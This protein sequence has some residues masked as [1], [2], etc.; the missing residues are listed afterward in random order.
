MLTPL[1]WLAVGV[2]ILVLWVALAGF[3]PL[4]LRA[5][6]MERLERDAA[7][8]AEALKV[9]TFERQEQQRLE[10]LRAEEYARQAQITRATEQLVGEAAHD[11]S[12]QISLQDD[13]LGRLREHDRLLCQQAFAGVCGA[14][15]GDTGRGD[16]ALSD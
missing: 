7:L 11:P 4:G 12:G 16:Q 1:G 13:R 14:G 2:I 9:R 10:R 3:D 8:G 5:R 15:T 6:R